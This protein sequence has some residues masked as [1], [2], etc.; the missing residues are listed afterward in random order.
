MEQTALMFNELF[1]RYPSLE[2]C[3]NDIYNAFTAMSICFKN[4][5]KVLCCGNGGSAAD[6]DHFAGELLKGFLKKRPLAEEEKSKFKNGFI[7]DNLQ[8]GLPVISLCTHSALMTAFE[9]D[10]VPSLVFAQQVYAYAQEND[11]LFCMS[12]S[13][14]SENVVYAAQTAKAAGIVSVAIT[15]KSESKLSE[16]CDIC[17]RLPESETYKIQELTLP[18]YH[19]IAAMLEDYFFDK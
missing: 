10:V 15:G 6:C 3:R 7:A 16:I 4:G 12:T 17:I 2:G 19:C 1:R 9:N 14:N 8:K 18:V 5:G 13:G 11:V